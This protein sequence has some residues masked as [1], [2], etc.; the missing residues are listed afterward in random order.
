MTKRTDLINDLV[1]SI[2]I[3]TQS[4]GERGLVYL[5]EI[6]SFPCFYIYPEQEK[7]VH[8]GDGRRWGIISFALRG[9]TSGDTLDVA[10]LY[11]RQLETAIQE[12]ANRPDI[13]EARVQSV[14][15][16]EGLMLPYGL[17]DIKFQ[18]L[19]EVT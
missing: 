17:A 13:Q 16:D 2:A 7:R 18:L 9:Y 4:Y 3:S 11:V 6:N 14:R 10:E 15:T 19:Y 12:F 5:H 8:E 1:S